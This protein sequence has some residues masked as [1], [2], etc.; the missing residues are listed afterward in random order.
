MP[1][2]SAYILDV[3]LHSYVFDISIYGVLGQFV[4]NSSTSVGPP[5]PQG[6]P[7]YTPIKG[8]DYWDGSKGDKGD[9]GDKGDK[10]DKGDT[11]PSFAD[12]SLGYGLYWNNTTFKVDVSIEADVT[13]IYVD[14]SLSARD[15]SLNVLY[16]TMASNSSVNLAISNLNVTQYATNASV[17]L[18]LTE[19]VKPYATNA[20]VGIALLN[21]PTLTA[22]SIYATNASVNSALSIIDGSIASLTNADKAFATNASVGNA[23]LNYATLTSLQPYATNASIA[24]ANFLEEVS[25]NVSKFKWVGGYLEP[26]IITSSVSTLASLTDVSIVS[27]ANAQ[28]IQYESSTSKWKNVNTVDIGTVFTTYTYVD[29]SL[30]AKTDKTYSVKQ[31]G[32]ISLK[33]DFTYSV[34][35]DASIALKADKTYVDGSLNAKTD[36]AYSVKQDASIALKGDISYNIKQDASIGLKTDFTY[37]VKQDSSIALKADKTYVDGS[38]NKKLNNTTDTFTGTLTVN[39]SLYIVGNMYQDGSTYVIHSQNLNTYADF[40]TMREGAVLQLPDGS[41]AG[42]KII[43]PNGTNNVIFGT[44]KDAIL[45]IGW[46]GGHLQALATREDAP[47]DQW[48]V[49]WDD[50][51]TMFKTRDLKTYLDGSLN[52]KFN[53]QAAVDTHI[54]VGFVNRTDSSLTFNNSNRVFT[55][56]KLNNFDVYSDGVKFTKTT[57]V[58]VQIGTTIGNHFNYIDSTGVLKTMTTPWTISSSNSPVSIV[59]WNGTNGKLFEERHSAARNVAWHEWAHD[60]IGCRY[61]SG[62]LGTFTN[63]STNIAPGVVHDEDIDFAIGV[64]NANN[65]IWYRAVGGATMTFDASAS[66]TA[67]K[68]TAGALQWDNAGTLT[69]VASGAY[70]TNHVYATTC[71]DTPIMVVVAQQEY[72]SGNAAARLDAARNAPLPTFPNIITPELKLIYRVIWTNTGGTPTY[73]ESQDYRTVSSLPG[74]ASGSTV[75]AASVLF[76]PTGNI[77]ATTVQAAIVELDNEKASYIYVDASLNVKTDFAYSV[78]QDV[79]IGLKTDF[80]YSVKQDASIVLKTDFTYSVKQD[81]SILNNTN[82]FAKYVKNASTRTGLYWVGGYLDVSI[83]SAS[84]IATLTDVSVA[85]PSTGQVLAFNTT[86]N[87]WESK[88][89]NA[90]LY[91][92]VNASDYFWIFSD[93]SLANP[94]SGQ[95]LIYDTSIS[96]FRNM[97]INASMYEIVNASEYVQTKI[98]QNSPST[99]AAGEQGDWSFDASYLYICTSTNKW[100]RILGVTG[101]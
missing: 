100:M 76:T 10:G 27:I 77:S 92:V 32:S 49:Y 64:Q 59:Y 53:Q 74:G 12:T 21:Y 4:I 13:K 62:L 86:Y 94:A 93:V 15:V 84:S 6:L 38:L 23:L 45:R 11:G 50:A 36:F 52:A 97:T 8:I 5:G 44:N 40:I 43:K 25:L 90:S 87:K 47:T 24:T 81:G 78:K 20:S 91:D 28:V 79:S 80:T 88:T 1:D 37:S 42:L 19:V 34:K 98:R 95:A 60:T 26:S 9:Q 58:S 39:G 96:K 63:S 72:I 7:G 61:E 71:F 82:E 18:A 31:D 48:Y 65:M 69:A 56:H 89:I 54:A 57:D 16:N 70:I 73:V 51:S 2:I 101:Y 22:V 75:N 29:A 35:Q 30:N 41:I 14:A 67:A 17:G 85:N 3:S 66:A 99:G 46:E 55:I 33:T 83:A 68:I